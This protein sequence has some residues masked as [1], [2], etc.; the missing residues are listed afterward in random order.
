MYTENVSK[1]GRKYQKQHTVNYV[2]LHI[3][4]HGKNRRKQDVQTAQLSFWIGFGILLAYIQAELL[5]EQDRRDDHDLTSCFL[6]A[7]FIIAIYS[8]FFWLQKYI[9]DIYVKIALLVWPVSFFVISY[10]FQSASG[11]FG[12]NVWLTYCISLSCFICW[13]ILISLENQWCCCIR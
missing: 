3:I 2:K 10:L 6:S 8:V 11:N 1:N 7:L 12:V 4:S 5:R 9:E 13:G